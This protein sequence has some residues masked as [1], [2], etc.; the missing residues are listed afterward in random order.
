MALTKVKAGVIGDDQIVNAAVGA[1]AIG[2]TEIADDAVTSAKLANATM[3][4]LCPAGSIIAYAGASLPDGWI[5]C[6]GQSLARAGTYAAL[7]AAISTTYGS[8]DGN[9]FNVPDLRGRAI[10]GQD[11]MGGTSANRLTSPIN[12]DTLGAAGG[13]ETHTLTTAEI[14]AHTH[15]YTVP[16]GTAAGNLQRGDTAEGGTAETRTSASTGG[17]GAHTNVQPTIILNYIIKI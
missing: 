5:W 10:A 9:S 3:Q 13:G 15:T 14:P 16:S 1:S 12:G 11:D 2:T 7:F 6:Y 4:A 8:V 17:G